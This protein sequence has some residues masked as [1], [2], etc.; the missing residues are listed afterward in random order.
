MKKGQAQGTVKARTA[1]DEMDNGA[2]KRQRSG[3]RAVV[4]ADA[5]YPPMAGRYHL[6]VSFACPWACRCLSVLNMKGLESIIGVRSGKVSVSPSLIYYFS[7]AHPTW[8]RTRPDRPEDTH[9]GW[10]F[11]FGGKHAFPDTTNDHINGTQ[12]VRN[13]YELSTDQSGNA[14]KYTVPVLWDTERRTIVNNESEDIMRML[15]SAFDD[16]AGPTQTQSQRGLD[17]YPLEK[18][19]DIDAINAWTYP[20]INDGVYRC[21][22]ATT[23]IVYDTAVTALY[24]ALDRCEAILS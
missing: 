23:Q 22:F 6:Y 5:R 17:L 4:G 15:N 7:V 20:D 12:Y 9:R 2:F 8:Q 18:R 3:Y 14:G 1:L 13:V 21:G 24:R 10:V 16:V 19:A 11:K